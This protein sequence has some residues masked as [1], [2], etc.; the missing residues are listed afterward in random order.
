[1]IPSLT[2]TCRARLVLW[3]FSIVILTGFG[4]VFR[5]AVAADGP[6]GKLVESRVMLD[7]DMHWAQSP[8]MADSIL[9]RIKAAGFNVYVPCVWHGNGTFFPSELTAPDP[10]LVDVMRSGRDP[11]AYLIRRAHSMGI[12]VHPWFTVVRREN[13]RYPQYYDRGTPNEAYDVH[14]PAFRRFIVELMLDVVRRYDVDGINMDFI[15][16]MG[17]CRSDRCRNDYRIR[18]ERSIDADLLVKSAAGLAALQRWNT[19]AVT[20][21]V[22]EVAEKAKAMKPRLIVSVDVHMLNPSLAL[23]GQDAANWTNSGWVDAVFQMD[24]RRPFDAEEAQRARALLSD[25]RKMLLILKL[26]DRSPDRRIVPREPEAVAEMVR[27]IRVLWPRTGVAFYHYVQLS[28]PQ[29]ATF[30]EALFSEP[31]TPAWR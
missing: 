16:S 24:Y 7:E 30:G 26:F 21:I 23:E 5:G 19:D 8:A 25:P 27:G 12:E 1:M 31:A 18:H 4:G 17:M 20:D 10:K 13:D 6:R 28:N 29:A 14:N 9:A 3:C 22:R 11:L 15:R 2:R